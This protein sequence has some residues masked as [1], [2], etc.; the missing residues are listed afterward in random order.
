MNSL[1]VTFITCSKLRWI[2]TVLILLWFIS[3]KRSVNTTRSWNI[4]KSRHNNQSHLDAG[5]IIARPY[6]VIITVF[7]SRTDKMVMSGIVNAEGTL[8][9]NASRASTGFFQHVPDCVFNAHLT[10]LAIKR[11]KMRLK[12]FKICNRVAANEIPFGQG[13]IHGLPVS[14]GYK[15]LWVETRKL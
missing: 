9:W 13:Q 5:A 7:R 11:V 14:S 10:P 2:M 12:V 1:S 8:V 4:T 15:A 6:W 3:S